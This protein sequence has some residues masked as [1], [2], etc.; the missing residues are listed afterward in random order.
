MKKVYELYTLHEILGRRVK[1]YFNLHK[2]TWSIKDKSTGLVIGYANYV[3][4]KD[5]VF[6]VSEAGRQRVL[7]EKRKNVHAYVEGTISF[8]TLDKS[9]LYH[10]D[11]TYNPYKYDSFVHFINGKP[12]KMLGA[13]FATLICENKKPRQTYKNIIKY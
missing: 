8:D 5:C 11:F 4:M 7:K 9:E 13:D 10:G 12:V 3:P 1:V 2:K 6:K